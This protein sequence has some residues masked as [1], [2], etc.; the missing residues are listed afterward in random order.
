MAETFN[1]LWENAEKAL[2]EETNLSSSEDLVKEIIAKFK[3]YSLVSNSGFAEEDCSRLRSHAF[4]KILLAITQLSFKDNV[5]VYAA[6]KIAL[7]EAK[8][9]SFEAKYK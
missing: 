7:D 5:N 8:L 3:L 4:G 6:L 2:K 9:N 1:E